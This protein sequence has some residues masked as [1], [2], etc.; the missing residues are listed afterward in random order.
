M[1]R[2]CRSLRSVLVVSVLCVSAATAGATDRSRVSP[3]DLHD[4]GDIVVRVTLNGNGPFRFLLDTGSSRSAVS[5]SVANALMLVPLAETALIT[6][7]GR[8]ERPIAVLRR[9]ELGAAPPTNVLAMIVPDAELQP[10]RGVDGIV[11]Q[12]V[13]GSLTYT[14]DYVK[15]H[16]VWH[17]TPPADVDGHRLTLSRSDYGLLVT[18]PQR[19]GSE[20][21]HFVPDTGANGWVLFAERP[22]PSTTLLGT[23]SVHSLSGARSAASAL[24]EELCVGA[25]TFRNQRAVIITRDWPGRPLGDGLLPLHLFARVTFNPRQHQLIVE[26]R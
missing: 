12:D 14:I 18:L 11:G 24:I 10:S 26:E 15:R 25:I 16:I 4:G 22:L 3:F 23:A 17:V 21:L 1:W 8:G 7:T 19:S 9:L 13:L 6:P 20:D 2:R 5:A